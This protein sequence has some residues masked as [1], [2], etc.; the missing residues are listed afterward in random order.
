M[1]Q[2]SSLGTAVKQRIQQLRK[3]VLLDSLPKCKSRK[4]KLGQQSSAG[5]GLIKADLNQLHSV[6]VFALIFTLQ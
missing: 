4:G 6:R 5:D 2:R 3:Q 1:A